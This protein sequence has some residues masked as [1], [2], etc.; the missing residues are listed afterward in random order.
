MSYLDKKGCEF[1]V[2]KTKDY[3]TTNKPQL[4]TYVGT[5]S[6]D[7]QVG[8][9][10]T[11]KIL[12]FAPGVPDNL[13]TGL[14][15]NHFSV[16]N[17]GFICLDNAPKG[18]TNTAVLITFHIYTFNHWTAGKKM[19]VHFRRTPYKDSGASQRIPNIKYIYLI[20]NAS[21]YLTF[22]GHFYYDLKEG[23]GISLDV[24]S[25]DGQGIISRGDGCDTHLALTTVI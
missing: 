10:K 3:F 18:E 8:T 19:Y 25:S 15:E 1:L 20:P 12:E 21:P 6:A 9:D 16:D 17:Y 4:R 13:C 14:A 11:P 23:E 22:S 7:T 2:K 5:L 24:Y